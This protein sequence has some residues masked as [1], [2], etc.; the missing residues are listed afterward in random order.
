MTVER[1]EVQAVQ[2]N[3]FHT[4][5]PH[6][7]YEAKLVPEPVCS[8]N[9]CLQTILCVACADHANLTQSNPI[10]DT[11]APMFSAR[12]SKPMPG[13]PLC[14]TIQSQLHM[15]SVINEA[16]KETSKGLVPKPGCYRKACSMIECRQVLVPAG[17]RSA[18]GQRCGFLSCAVSGP[19]VW[20]PTTDADELV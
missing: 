1:R 17:Q 9:Q 3:L 15:Q 8:N 7:C 19:A 4:I 5:L 10:L 20:C 12:V 16:L 13:M 2:T 18:M 11:E 14:D 6:P